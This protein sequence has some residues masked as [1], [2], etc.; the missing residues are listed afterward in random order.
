MLLIAVLIF[1]F[2]FVLFS[3]LAM[4][5][6]EHELKNGHSND[7]EKNGLD[8]SRSATSVNLNL[9]MKNDA[10]Q[11]SHDPS[12]LTLDLRYSQSDAHRSPERR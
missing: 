10:L 9:S 6:Y 4:A 2:A 7:S 3:L 8:P 11:P 5:A 1:G 12:G